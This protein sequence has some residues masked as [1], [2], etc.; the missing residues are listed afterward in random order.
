MTTRWINHK[1]HNDNDLPGIDYGPPQNPSR[2]QPQNMI[3]QPIFKGFGYSITY[4][5]TKT[6][7]LFPNYTGWWSDNLQNKDNTLLAG[8]SKSND[9]SVGQDT[10]LPPSSWINGKDIKNPLATN[11]INGRLKNIYACL[12]NQNRV[13]VSPSQTIYAYLGN[14]FQNNIVPVIPELNKVDPQLTNYNC[15][16]KYQ[17]SPYNIS[18]ID[19]IVETPT[20][21]D[22][23]YFA[24]NLRGGARENI[25][26]PYSLKPLS[27]NKYEGL[28]KV[29]DG[30]RFVYWNPVNGI[31]SFLMIDNPVNLVEAIRN[32][33]TIEHE[34]FPKITTTFN[35]E[36][37]HLFKVYDAAEINRQWLYE[38]YTNNN[39]FGDSTISVFVGGTDATQCTLNP[40]KMTYVKYTFY[41][42]AGFDWNMKKN[43]INFTYLGSEPIS[44]N[45]LL[46]G[47]VHA[48]QAPLAYNFLIPKIPDEIKNYITLVPSDHNI[49]V[50]PQLFDFE[51]IN[52]VTIKD[53]FKGDYFYKLTINANFPTTLMGKVYEIPVEINYTYF[54][55]LPGYNDPTNF[56]NYNLTAPSIKFGVPYPSGHQYAGQVYYT[57]GYSTD[58]VIQSTIPK[59]WSIIDAKPIDTVTLDNI[60]A[61]AGDPKTL[62]SSL[63]SIWT[64]ISTDSL[65]LTS[66]LSGTN[67]LVNVSFGS[68]AKTFPIKN[69]ALPDIASVYILM[70]MN[71]SQLSYGT[72][73]VISSPT[74]YYNCTNSKIKSAIIAAPV[75]KNVESRGAWLQVT[76]SGKIVNLQENGT[77]VDSLDQNV[78][79]G[80]TALYRA[81][82]TLYNKGTDI[83]YS[84]NLTISY[85]KTVK[86]IEST[87]KDSNI[88]YT[89]ENISDTTSSL[90]LILNQQIGLGESIMMPVCFNYTIPMTSR[91]NLGSIPSS[92]TLIT[93]VSAQMS[94]TATSDA[95]SV[96]AQSIAT[97]LIISV[98]QR[99]RDQVRLEGINT[100]NISSPTISLNATSKFV[101]TLTNKPIRYTF[102][103]KIVN[104]SC[105]NITC[106]GF[107]P[108]VDYIAVCNLSSTSVYVDTPTLSGIENITNISMLYKVITVDEKKST[109][110]SNEWMLQDN[111]VIAI[112]SE[113]SQPFPL[114]A[115]IIIIVGALSVGSVVLFIV[116][117]TKR[118]NQKVVDNEG[119][120]PEKLPIESEKE[121]TT[122]VQNIP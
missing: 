45:D 53:G 103:R 71:I 100:G 63:A 110:A 99:E 122:N 104:A 46:C 8:Q 80:D 47:L 5:S 2:I 115:I 68:F 57:S 107:I 28:A 118:A 114:Y 117:R 102:Y 90:K 43:A 87:L 121:Q 58:V 70:K 65:N 4:S 82:M 37:Y 86:L 75:D 78:F 36:I 66:K 92:Q 15:T 19:N 35:A 50:A 33:L 7:P 6:L 30:G 42:N 59:D 22:W 93:G 14:V 16:G 69:G 61:A 85:L 21:R 18:M 106:V 84:V 89:V 119:G 52:V 11:I 55:R 79:P 72:V 40:G 56:H 9:Y 105:G 41:N 74:V 39:G 116:I 98:I 29:Q 48:I 111:D 17:Y 62:K 25:N 81:N 24:A 77:M 31:N 97:P 109:L 13:R 113:V 120:T 88:S 96:V 26:I 10:L 23:L 51:N 67:N 64:A 60:R 3:A 76:Y 49:N 12:F 91:R 94:L 112:T 95:T 20:I 1:Y 44:A 32:D 108:D 38:T 101:K 54:D 73:K 27:G 34:A 83:A